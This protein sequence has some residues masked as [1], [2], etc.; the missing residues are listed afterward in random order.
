MSEQAAET[1]TTL[2]PVAKSIFV[3]CKKCDANRYQTV[4][5]HATA[6]SAKIKCEVCGAKS[7]F[8]LPKAA[9]PAGA[10]KSPTGAALKRQTA[11]AT[12]KKNAHADEFNNLAAVA[13]GDAHNYSMKAKFQSNQRVSHPKFGTGYV[14]SAQVDKI[15]VVFE[16]EVRMLVH[17][18]Q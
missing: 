11:S 16:D 12:A 17:N 3:F 15:E 9:K 10:K 13:K 2:P 6:T 18:R 1:F 5:A 4:L 14:R 7:T 8:K